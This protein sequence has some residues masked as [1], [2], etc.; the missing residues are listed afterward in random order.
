[1]IAKRFQEFFFTRFRDSRLVNLLF[2]A[3]TCGKNS[4]WT[5]TKQSKCGKNNNEKSPR[6]KL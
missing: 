3:R 4:N 2:C 6:V 5:K 1:M